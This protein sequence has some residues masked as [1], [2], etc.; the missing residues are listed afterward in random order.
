MV[1]TGIMGAEF[2]FEMNRFARR[3]EFIP[4]LNLSKMI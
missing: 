1:K 4:S 3:L 2:D